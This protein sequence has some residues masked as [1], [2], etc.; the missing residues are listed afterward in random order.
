MTSIALINLS[1]SV[2]PHIGMH[3]YTACLEQ[4]RLMCKAWGLPRARLVYLVR[5][6]PLD[7]FTFPVFILDNVHQVS[8][9]KDDGRPSRSLVVQNVLKQKGGGM[10]Q[11]PNGNSVSVLV[12]RLVIELFHELNKDTRTP[13]CSQVASTRCTVNLV[14]AKVKVDVSNFVYPSWFDPNGRAPFDQA[15]HCLGPR[16]EEVPTAREAKDDPPT[17]ASPEKAGVTLSESDI[18]TYPDAPSPPS[19]S[20][21]LTYPEVIQ[22]APTILRPHVE[23]IQAP[24]TIVA[25]QVIQVRR[26]RNIRELIPKKSVDTYFL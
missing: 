17:T 4:M 1:E 12:S 19:E 11:G 5:L 6:G 8:G 10:L 26:V 3:M 2:K 21:I 16:A 20:D 22:D 13:I 7:A 18:L 24:A 15:G 9:W 23:K 25:P 14:N